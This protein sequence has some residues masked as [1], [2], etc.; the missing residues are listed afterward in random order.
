MLDCPEKQRQD[1]NLVHKP[2]LTDLFLRKIVASMIIF[3]SLSKDY[4]E[5]HAQI[6]ADVLTYNV[7][8]AILL[9]E[10]DYKDGM[11]SNNSI[12]PV[13]KGW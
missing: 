8:K 6:Y 3:P 7:Q 2:P 1:Y 13:K 4:E 9:L 12:L 11:D 10:D 5:P